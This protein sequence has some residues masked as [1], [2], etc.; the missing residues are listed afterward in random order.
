MALL[1]TDLNKFFI[2]PDEWDVINNLCRIFEVKLFYYL[3]IILVK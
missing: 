3:K 2:S 1:D